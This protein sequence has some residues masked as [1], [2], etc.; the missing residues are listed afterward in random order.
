[1]SLYFSLV[2]YALK[3]ARQYSLMLTSCF[4]ATVS[5]RSQKAGGPP[6][7]CSGLYRL[8]FVLRDGEGRVNLLANSA[9][10]GA[11]RLGQSDFYFTR[12][13]NLI[14]LR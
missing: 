10:I 7:S 5:P 1:M 6:Y 3:I 4:L 8:G 9:R 11:A 14:S 12:S 2:A 13:G